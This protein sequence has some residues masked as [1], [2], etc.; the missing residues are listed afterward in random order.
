IPLPRY[1]VRAARWRE[2]GSSPRD[3]GWRKRAYP[4]DEVIAHARS[5]G[6]VGVRLRREDLVLDFDPRNYPDGRD[7]AEY[8]DAAAAAF[9]FGSFTAMV[10]AAPAVRTGSGGWH[11]Y[12]RKPGDLAVQD[13][14]PGWRGVEFKSFG[15][16]VV[17]AGSIHPTGTAY[18]WNDDPVAV[19]DAPAQ[20]LAIARRAGPMVAS[21]DGGQIEAHRLTDVL[22][23]FDPTDFRE[24]DR[25]L[26]L[27]MASHHATAGEGRQEFIDWC[28][29]DP[30]FVDHA[31]E[32]GR[33]WDSLHADKQGGYTIATL[34]KL[35]DEAGCRDR[36]DLATRSAPEDD[37]D[38]W[39]EE[40]ADEGGRASGRFVTLEQVAAFPETTWLVQ[41]WLPDR[42]VGALW[43]ETGVGKSFMAFHIGLCVATGMSCFGRN[44]RQ[45]N[46]VYIAGENPHGFRKRWLAWSKHHGIEQ[47]SGFYLHV[48][49][50][51]LNRP[52]KAQELAR[53][54]LALTPEPV[55][56]IIDTLSAN[57]EG[58]ETDEERAAAY[59]RLC[60]QV[61][62]ITGA[63]V[64]YLHHPGKDVTKGMRGSSAL[65]A[66]ADFSLKMEK[67]KADRVTVTVD[68]QRDDEAGGVTHYSLVEV[69]VLPGSDSPNSLVLVPEIDADFG[70]P[71][72][73]PALIAFLIGMNGST[74]DAAAEAA[75]AAGFARSKPTAKTRIKAAVTEHGEA[76]RVSLE[77]VN[78]SNKQSALVVSVEGR[79]DS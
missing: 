48:G 46:V 21:A 63:A 36:V 11:V 17:A 39:R 57:S 79:D 71:A 4:E 64:M 19:P 50:V 18:T 22:D 49:P 14:H 43:G 16:Q 65:K 20:L 53:D 35:A 9:G 13:T 27:M 1:S 42:Q 33:R 29:Q 41:G 8:E 61:R 5:G 62:D 7:H 45:G 34:Y 2:R 56:I 70:A 15:R 52:N 66:N 67:G 31:S 78:P 40:P 51:L 37:F 60:D 38:E 32:V 55:L 72:E 44:V 76:H 10:D 3:P 58:A 12:L 75:V 30:Q 28:T 59:D 24:H 47:V 68:K 77:R 23:G 69:E 25:W 74:L 6:N 73:A 26:E 54:I